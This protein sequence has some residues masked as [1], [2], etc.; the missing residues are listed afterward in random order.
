MGKK[1]MEG[2]GMTVACVGPADK[3]R[4][5][6]KCWAIRAGFEEGRAHWRWYELEFGTTT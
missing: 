3:R 1:S 5:G 4:L 6:A 2:N